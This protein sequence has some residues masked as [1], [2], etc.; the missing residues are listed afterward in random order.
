MLRGLETDEGNF[1]K[2]AAIGVYLEDAAVPALARKWAD[3]TAD[4]LASDP[5]FFGDV[6]AGNIYKKMDYAHRN[7]GSPYRRR[8]LVAC[9]SYI[10]TA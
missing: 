10:T 9:L 7:T 5:D 4:E 8:L 2:I 1:V 3:K 6:H